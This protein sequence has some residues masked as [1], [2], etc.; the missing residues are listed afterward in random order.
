MTSPGEILVDV[1]IR[2]AALEGAVLAGDAT[3][4][5]WSAN[6]PEQIEAALAEAGYR[7]VPEGRTCDV[8]HG[9]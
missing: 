5:V 1:V 2:A 6:A 3:I 7:L 8:L 9:K 4:F